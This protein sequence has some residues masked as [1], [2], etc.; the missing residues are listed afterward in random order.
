MQCNYICIC[1]LVMMMCL[2]LFTLHSNSNFDT[3]QHHQTFVYCITIEK[4]K[5]KKPNDYVISHSFLLFTTPLYGS[6]LL[7]CFLLSLFSI[8][9][10]FLDI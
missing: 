7:F 3:T 10:Y 4:K 2:F 1:M 6:L 5:K 9:F 8:F